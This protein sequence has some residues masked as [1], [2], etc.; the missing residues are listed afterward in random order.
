MEVL[1]SH[2]SPSQCQL[3]VLQGLPVT[4]DKAVM[5]KRED[6]LGAGEEGLSECQKA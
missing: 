3:G 4:D 5:V 2:P 6:S 1:P